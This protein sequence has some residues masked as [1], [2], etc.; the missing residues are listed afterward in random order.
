M[1]IIAIE[2]NCLESFSTICMSI[3]GHSSMKEPKLLWWLIMSVCSLGC[4]K[5]FMSLW[6]SYVTRQSEMLAWIQTFMN[7]IE[8]RLDVFID[9]DL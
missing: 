5:E 6:L 8:M 4:L 1:V 7:Q 2:L 3:Q 9:L